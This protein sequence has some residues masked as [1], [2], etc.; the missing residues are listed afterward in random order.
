[1]FKCIGLN[2]GICV[3]HRNM[4][5][6]VA[7]NPHRQE[8]QSREIETGTQRRKLISRILCRFEKAIQ[9]LP[10]SFIVLT[11]LVFVFEM[12]KENGKCS[13]VP[14]ERKEESKSQ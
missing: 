2:A 13:T 3:A 8:R 9:V 12:R 11:L 5:V 14:S 6:P 10:T 4:A 1:M 7:Q